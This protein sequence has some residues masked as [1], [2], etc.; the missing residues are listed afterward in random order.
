M[1]DLNQI[2]SSP[3]KSL[4]FDFTETKAGGVLRALEAP[5]C[6]FAI[7]KL[8]DKG[9]RGEEEFEKSMHKTFT[10]CYF[11]DEFVDGGWG[12]S[13]SGND[14]DGYATSVRPE[15][16]REEERKLAFYP[17][18]WKSLEVSYRLRLRV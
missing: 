12:Y 4:E 2:A 14:A 8:S 7:I 11:D 10:D 18:G 15:E 1:K 13:L 16:L 3:A 9:P 5:V 6:E 17:L